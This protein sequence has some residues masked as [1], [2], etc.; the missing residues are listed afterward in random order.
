MRDLGMEVIAFEDVFCQLH[1]LLKPAQVC[2]EGHPCQN[3]RAILSAKPPTVIIQ[4]GRVVLAN[5]LH[6]ERV[7]LTGVLFSAMFN[8]K[9][10]LVCC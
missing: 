7:K 9:S 4:E 8:C 10:C 6:R 1:D 3:M 2:Y 5:F